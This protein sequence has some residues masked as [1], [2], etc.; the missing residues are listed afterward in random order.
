MI[1]GQPWQWTALPPL[2]L[3]GTGTPQVESLDSYAIRIAATQG[4]TPVAL[5]RQLDMWGGY[6]SSK[7]VYPRTGLVGPG[8][9]F[10]ERVHT[11]ERLTGGQLLRGGTFY[12]VVNALRR[13]QTGLAVQRRWCCLCLAE[14]RKIGLTAKLSWVFSELSACSVHGVMITEA[15]PTCGEAQPYTMSLSSRYSCSSCGNTLLTTPHYSHELSNERQWVDRSIEE[16][17]EYL[18]SHAPVVLPGGYERYLSRLC[19]AGDLLGKEHDFLTGPPSLGS[20]LRL[21]AYMGVTM[22][23]ILIRQDE[24]PLERLVRDRDEPPSLATCDG[25]ELGLLRKIERIVKEAIKYRV[26]P[27]PS[28]Q[29]LLAR[30]GLTHAPRALRQ[31]FYYRRYLRRYKVQP[32]PANPKLRTALFESCFRVLD[33]PRHPK[34]SEIVAT[35]CK[36]HR[37]SPQI[38]RKYVRATFCMVAIESASMKAER[39]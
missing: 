25:A 11:L 16:L 10:A 26:S 5:V 6:P 28:M 3:Y 9:R 15:C 33:S 2:K 20:L 19:I 18:S 24:L 7:T 4:M 8:Y 35:Q 27:L 13:Q 32:S 14:F 34:L 38:V 17:V 36:I 37:T 21:S 29:F 12:S 22:L 31:S 1:T 23:D 30:H 39:D